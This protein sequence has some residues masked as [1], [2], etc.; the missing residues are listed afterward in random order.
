M[1]ALVVL[2]AASQDESGREVL[3]RALKVGVK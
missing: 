3:S 2:C 1:E